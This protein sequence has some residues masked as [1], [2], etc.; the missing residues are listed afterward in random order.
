MDGAVALGESLVENSD[1]EE[2]RVAWNGFHLRGCMAIGHALKHNSSLLSLDLT[3]NRISELCLAQ[4]LKGLQD[5]STLQVLKLPLNPLSPQSAYSILQFIDK[6]S[7]MALSHV[8]LGDQE[9]RA[10]ECPVVYENPLI[11]LMEFCRLQNLRLVDMFNNIDKDRSKSLSYQEFQDGLQRVNIPLADHSLQQLM[12][13]LDKNK[14]GEIDFGELIDGQ[15]EYKRLVQDAL[16][17]GPMDSN[18]VGQIG[19]KM[20]QHIHDKYLM[21]KKF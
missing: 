1:L 12:T 5:N 6:H 15:R 3:C 19:I 10:E 18:I 21:R 2:L 8:D 20:K 14:D 17:D 4:L 9:E 13:E 11:V 7:N 16:R